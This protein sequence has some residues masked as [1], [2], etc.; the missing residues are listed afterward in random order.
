MRLA[1]ST[2]V[3]Q[4]GASHVNPNLPLGWLPSAAGHSTIYLQSGQKGPPCLPE[5]GPNGVEVYIERLLP[6]ACLWGIGRESMRLALGNN[7]EM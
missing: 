2:E 1:P 7:R 5:P 4:T 6:S 3:Y